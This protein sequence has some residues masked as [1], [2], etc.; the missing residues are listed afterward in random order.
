VCEF[1][2]GLEIIIIIIIECNAMQ[3]TAGRKK[4]KEGK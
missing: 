4:R 1:F 2:I 3:T